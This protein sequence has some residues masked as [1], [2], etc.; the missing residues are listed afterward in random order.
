MI[1][2]IE[3]TFHSTIDTAFTS[4]FMDPFKGIEPIEDSSFQLGH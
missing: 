2:A 1:V 4:S 3:E